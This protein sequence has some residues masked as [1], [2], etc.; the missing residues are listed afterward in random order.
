MENYVIIVAG[1]KGVRTGCDMPKQ[2]IPIVNRPLLMHT[3]EAFH[4]Y[5]HAI[6]IILVLPDG[7]EV[8]WRNICADHGFIIPH[9]I[10]KGGETRFHSV[11]NGL[12]IV[13]RELISKEHETFNKT[14]IGIHDGARP[15]I[16]SNVISNVYQRA[17]SDGGAF[18]AIPVT[19]SIRKTT[20]K[21]KNSV[22]VDRTKYFLV[23]TPQVFKADILF[24]AY[25]QEYKTQFTDDVSVVE[26]AGNCKPSMVEG[27]PRNIKITVPLD[28]AVAEALMQDQSRDVNRAY[29]FS[30]P[31]VSC[32]SKY[33]SE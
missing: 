25:K 10:V 32:G 4:I 14:L 1:G 3:I 9:L 15:L 11:K 19:D 2:F 12:A 33:L 23:Q 28:F 7:Q 20:A 26:A 24:K 6:R 21:G 27:N 30:K 13:E 17:S 16:D 29:S 22:S 31:A 8:Y 5:N 18:P